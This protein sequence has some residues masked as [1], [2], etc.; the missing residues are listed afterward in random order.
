MVDNLKKVKARKKQLKT[1]RR[2]ENINYLI[3]PS[4]E[5]E[6][7]YERPPSFNFDPS[8]DAGHRSYLNR[9]AKAKRIR[10]KNPR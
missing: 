3:R 6:Q 9:K 5:D 1:S 7:K 10:Q 8:G 2:K 4:N